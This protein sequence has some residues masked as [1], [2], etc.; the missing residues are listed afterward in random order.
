MVKMVKK[1]VNGSL[2]N[3]GRMDK[4]RVWFD[5]FSSRDSSGR[6]RARFSVFAGRVGPV[7]LMW[8]TRLPHP[9]GEGFA[10]VC[11]GVLEC[12]EDRRFGTFFEPTR[13]PQ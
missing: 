5:R 6:L 4:T 2:V 3:L 9:V 7:G 11:W 8:K 13:G 12:G 1:R 10:L